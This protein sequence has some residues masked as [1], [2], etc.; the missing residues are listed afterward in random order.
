M[1]AATPVFQKQPEEAVKQ[2]LIDTLDRKELPKGSLQEILKDGILLCEYVLNHNCY[3]LP[4]YSCSLCRLIKRF[5]PNE[6][7]VKNEG[8]T[9]F[10]YVSNK[11]VTERQKHSFIDIHYSKITLAN[12]YE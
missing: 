4:L 5:S 9:K 12:S 7:I 6:C 10:A 1:T 8:H 11:L 3:T 2:F